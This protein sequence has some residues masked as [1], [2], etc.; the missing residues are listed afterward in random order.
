MAAMLSRSQCVNTSRLKQRVRHLSTNLK[1]RRTVLNPSRH[2][3]G[4]FHATSQGDPETDPSQS[5]SLDLKGDA[6]LVKLP[7]HMEYIFRNQGHRMTVANCRACKTNKFHDDVIKCKN[8]PC[9]WPFVWGIHRSRVNSPHK[10]QWRGALMS[11]FP[12]FF[13]VTGPLCGE[14][15]GTGE[16][17]AQR[18]SYAE[19]DSIWWRHHVTGPSGTNE[20]V[21]EWISSMTFYGQRTPRSLWSI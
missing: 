11:S 3:I 14:F 12:C 5:L 7:V 15:T 4:V 1:I 16:F 19:N 2:N 6:I 13:H 20:W 8:F 9:Y 10:G 17:P 18:A 21:S